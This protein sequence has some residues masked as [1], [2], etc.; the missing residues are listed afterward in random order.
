MRREAGHG[1]TSRAYPTEPFAEL[2]TW[3]TSQ[4][5]IRS[6]ESDERTAMTQVRDLTGMDL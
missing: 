4:G 3:V 6:P 5:V 2:W 1:T